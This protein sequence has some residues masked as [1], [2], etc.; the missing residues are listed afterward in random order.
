MKRLILPIV[1]T[2]LSSSLVLGQK[3]TLQ[4]CVKV[5]MANNLTV[6]RAL[7]NVKSNEIGLFQAKGSFLPTINFNSS[8]NQNYGRTLNPLTYSYVNAVNKTIGPSLSSSL[9]L[10]NGFRL[11]NNYKQNKRNV[12]AADLDLEKAKNDVI[13]TV[14][15]NYTNVILNKE[16][17]DNSKFQLNS[18]QQQLERIQKQVAAGAL[19][20]SNELTQEATVATNET[21]LITQENIYNLSV[22]QLKQSMQ[23]PASTALEIVVPD[24]AMEDLSIN[25]TPEEIYSISAKSL[26][27]IR[28]A[29]LKVDAADY[30]VRA[31]RGSLFPRISLTSGANSNY[32]SASDNTKSYSNDLSTYAKTPTGLVDINDNPVYQYK[33]T[34]ATPFTT[35]EYGVNSQLTD[36]L[37]KSVGVSL[38]VPILNGL[39]NRS[40]LKQAVVNRELA[41]ITVKETENTLRQS[42][43]TAYNNA[44]AAAKTYTAAIKQVSANEEAF[45]MTRQRH[46]IGA[47]TYIEY[48]V[49][50]NDLYSAKSSLARAKYNFILTKKILEFYQGK[51]IEY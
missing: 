32:S 34:T 40:N 24:I 47:A 22:L 43:E 50:S 19:P 5:A 1:V 20:K 46:E 6:Q 39:Q 2:L 37:T 13:I 30:A 23:V 35:S 27:Q 21:N 49:A 42:I 48:Q 10:F 4:E 17:L 25:Q 11:Q 7:Y 8:F 18:S 45:R 51:T 41:S 15:S 38:T 12:E 31:A 33:P 16:L 29:M 3:M 28:S 44:F 9:L 36:Y 14:V 26:P